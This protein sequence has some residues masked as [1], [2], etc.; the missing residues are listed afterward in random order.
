VAAER[1]AQR[2]K[3]KIREFL[4]R[5]VTPLPNM[6]VIGEKLDG[7]VHFTRVPTPDFSVCMVRVPRYLEI[8]VLSEERT[9]GD[10]DSLPLFPRNH[11]F[12]EFSEHSFPIRNR[13]LFHGGP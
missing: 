9:E 6:R 8:D 5:V 1:A 2:A 4:L 7:S 11:L 13:G 3:T 12:R 10:A